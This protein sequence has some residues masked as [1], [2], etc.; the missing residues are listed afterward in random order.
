MATVD[1]VSG[2][3]I[4]CECQNV[5]LYGGDCFN[6]EQLLASLSHPKGSLLNLSSIILDGLINRSM[7]GL[8][9]SGLISVD[10]ICNE[11]IYI[12]ISNSIFSWF[13]T[14]FIH[15]YAFPLL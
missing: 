11:D 4:F 3:E 7:V 2:K 6:A 9:N 1:P 14:N 15:E 10:L 12:S 5:D 13:S 8:G